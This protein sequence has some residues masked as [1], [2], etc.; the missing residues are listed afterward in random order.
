MYEV[1]KDYYKQEIE[2]GSQKLQKAIEEQKTAAKWSIGANLASILEAQAGVEVIKSAKSQY[3]NN[4]S[5]INRNI[6][7]MQTTMMVNFEDS[8]AQLDSVAAAKNIDI[9]SQSIRGIKERGLRDMGEDFGTMDIQGELQK[10][11][12]DFQYK[13]QKTQAES[14]RNKTLLNSTENI[15]SA[16]EYLL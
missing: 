8:M 3:A 5:L 10:S 11:A 2:L 12:L 9:N 1:R 13:M 6:D 14:I 4:K 16:A 15:L 7:D